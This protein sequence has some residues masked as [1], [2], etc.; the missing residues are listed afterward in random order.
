MK[1]SEMDSLTTKIAIYVPSTIDIDSPVDN[2]AQV[3]KTACFLSDLFGG[4]TAFQASGYWIDSNKKLITENPVV[5]YAYTTKDKAQEAEE[6][7]IEYV[8]S[9]CVEMSQ[10]CISVE[11]NNK[12][13]FIN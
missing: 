12:L 11:Y 2:S 4:C 8:K 13:Y 6:K 7:I 5:V 1:F 9:L 10:D 3:K